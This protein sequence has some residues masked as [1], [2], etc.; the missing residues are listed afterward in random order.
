MHDDRAES[1]IARSAVTAPDPCVMWEP[2]KIAMLCVIPFGGV[3]VCS[4]GR[5][6]L[7]RQMGD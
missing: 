7:E 1:R 6:H 3:A 4:R 2:V 5:E